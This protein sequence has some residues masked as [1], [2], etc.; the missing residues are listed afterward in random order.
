MSRD[1]IERVHCHR[2]GGR[3]GG[4][5]VTGRPGLVHDGGRREVCRRRPAAPYQSRIDRRTKGPN[6]LRRRTNDLS[7]WHPRPCRGSGLIVVARGEM[8]LE[9]LSAIFRKS[10]WV[11]V[12]CTDRRRRRV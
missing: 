10:V 6:I 7:T 3:P 12:R 1:D 11:A 2:D 9:M 5:Y 4:S 8:N